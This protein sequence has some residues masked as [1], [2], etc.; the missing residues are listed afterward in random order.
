M[1][2]N[3]LVHSD[4][5][6]DPP[7]TEYEVFSFGPYKLFSAQR[8]LERSGDA[9]KLGGRAFDILMLLVRHAG[10]VV[11]HRQIHTTVWAGLIVDGSS[12]RFHMSALRKALGGAQLSCE[13]IVNVPGRGYCFVAPVTSLPSVS[14]A[15]KKNRDTSSRA[16]VHSLPPVLERM[17]GRQKAIHDISSE[18]LAERFVT[19]VGPGGIGKTTVAVGIGNSF[20]AK[21]PGP[22]Q[23]V[24]L[25]S[26]R[27]SSQVAAAVAIAIGLQIR[28]EDPV[29]SI[30]TALRTCQMLLIFDSCEHVLDQVAP[31]VEQIFACASE[32]FILATSREPLGAEGEHVFRLQPLRI[33]LEGAI[34]TSQELTE[35]SA[36]ELFLERVQ[37]GGSRIELNDA[38]V[39]TVVAICR[40]LDG[41]ALAIELAASRVQAYGLRKTADLLGHQFSL[42]WPGRRT[43][44]PRHQTLMATLDWSYNLLSLAERRLLYRL[45]VFIG[46]FDLEGVMVVTQVAANFF[47]PEDNADLS[48]LVAKSLVVAESSG[49]RTCYRLLDTTRNYG[50]RKLAESGEM[51]E[52]NRQHARYYEQVLIRQAQIEQGTGEWPRALAS[53]LND[54]RAAMSWALSKDG[55]VSLGVRLTAYSTS[56][57]LGLGLLP[58][59]RDRMKQAAAVADH[60]EATIEEKMLIQMALGSTVMFTVGL[61]EAFRTSWSSVL[62]LAEEIDDK[63]HQLNA[64]LALWAQQIRALNAGEAFV[65]ARRCDAVASKFGK[66]GPKA[67][68]LWMLGLCEHHTGRCESAKRHLEDALLSEDDADRMMQLRHFGYDRRVDALGVLSNTFW[69]LG[70][71]AD[72][73]E[74]SA[75][76]VAEARQL[77]YPI[78]LCIALA[79][80]CFNLYVIGAEWS[81]VERHAVTLI[82]HSRHH[83]IEAYQGFGICLQA[84]SGKPEIDA[85]ETASIVASGIKML[86]RGQ[87]TA[88]NPIFQ[89][90]AALMLAEAGLRIHA[91]TLFATMLRED[92]NTDHWCSP[93]IVRI[94]GQ[95]ALSRG[96]NREAEN[97][98]KMSIDSAAR[99]GSLAWQLRSANSL[100]AL[101]IN[102]GRQDLVCDLLSPL[103]ALFKKGIVSRDLQRAR[104]LL[105]SLTVASSSSPA[106]SPNTNGLGEN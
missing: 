88:F 15:A 13:Y 85:E 62:S 99:H 7:S 2:A 9:V 28:T 78:P 71:T 103:V 102:E 97:C 47:E 3:V 66:A 32:V 95:L 81:E 73:L 35:Y 48:S 93:E 51:E 44:L 72:A 39:E 5:Q 76:A 1:S 37:A 106:D 96:N 40:R 34:I 101:W 94:K 55:D 14:P 80:H 59:C 104:A 105:K 100:A 82:E 22:V 52:A 83:G 12:I 18:L 69:M 26:V 70:C 31:L 17:V 89:A 24:D 63:Q 74:T 53:N 49:E 30:L 50:L 36:I 25:A 87:Y 4:T 68:A 20:F 8:L 54:I 98:F 84:L 65:L 29:P 67:M 91:E 11:T 19:I 60:S 79:W 27:E 45:S 33:P 46:A 92:R 86:V 38:D 21:F 10:E 43:A 75:M 90:D 16:A 41:M 42:L 64:Y 61:G 23:F 77:D 6:G 57:W 58:E 56:L